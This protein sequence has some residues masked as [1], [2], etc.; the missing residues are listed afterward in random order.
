MLVVLDLSHPD[1]V[2]LIGGFVKEANH[3]VRG[4]R[5]ENSTG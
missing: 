2:S 4:I 1:L 3:D 5:I